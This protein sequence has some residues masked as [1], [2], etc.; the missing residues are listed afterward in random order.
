MDRK[1]RKR[2]R[3]A[4]TFELNFNNLKFGFDD[5]MIQN[6]EMKRLLNFYKRDNE[7]LKSR[8]SELEKSLQNAIC[9]NDPISG[10]REEMCSISD[11]VPYSR[12]NPPSYHVSLL[13]D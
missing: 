12:N 2:D 11:L 9:L 4:K 3:D 1:Y 8:I 5:L 7:M 10:A 6:N 13:R